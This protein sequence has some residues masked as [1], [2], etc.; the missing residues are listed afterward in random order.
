V[1]IGGVGL[2][3]GVCVGRGWRIRGRLV[4]LG[5]FCRGRLDCIRGG[6][7]MMVIYCT[8]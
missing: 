5:S 7:G 2:V 3:S 6:G 8:H 1:I 4:G